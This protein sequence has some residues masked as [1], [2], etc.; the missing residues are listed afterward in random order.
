MRATQQICRLNPKSKQKNSQQ[1]VFCTL[2]VE[3]SQKFVNNVSSWTRRKGFKISPEKT[4][5]K[6]IHN[7]RDP[8]IRFNGHRLEIKNTHKILGLIV[9]NRPTWKTH[10]NEMRANASKRMNLLKCLAGMNWGAD[11]KCY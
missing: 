5:R 4:C 6:R 2:K 7:H 10:I 8:E 11:Q 3:R 9:D 1:T